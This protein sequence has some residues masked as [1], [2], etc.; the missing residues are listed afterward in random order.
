MVADGVERGRWKEKRRECG[1]GSRLESS[2][3]S[4]IISWEDVTARCPGR[5]ENAKC[6]RGLRVG[7]L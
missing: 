4:K 3:V 5:V 6:S 2:V 7:F 1:R